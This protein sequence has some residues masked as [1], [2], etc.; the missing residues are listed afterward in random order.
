VLDS[1]RMDLRQ[2]EILSLRILNLIIQ[3]FWKD[4]EDANTYTAYSQV[5]QVFKLTFGAFSLGASTGN[6]LVGLSV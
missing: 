5:N 4:L 6:I 1:T 2:I 3:S